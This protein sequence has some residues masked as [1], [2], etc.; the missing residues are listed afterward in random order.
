MHVC[1]KKKKVALK[2]TS[3][4]WNA[5]REIKGL[6]ALKVNEISK[7]GIIKT[8]VYIYSIKLLWYECK[9]IGWNEHLKLLPILTAIQYISGSLTNEVS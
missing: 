3:G 9:I 7:G 5:T 6:G 2:V 8:G 1:K 4:R